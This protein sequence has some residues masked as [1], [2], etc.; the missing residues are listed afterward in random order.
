MEVKVKVEVEMVMVGTTYIGNQVGG[1]DSSID[2]NI[3]TRHLYLHN[4]HRH[5]STSSHSVGSYLDN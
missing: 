1:K 4:L 5:E 2:S 3:R